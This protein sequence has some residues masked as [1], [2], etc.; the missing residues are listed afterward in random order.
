MKIFKIA[1][2]IIAYHGTT[3]ENIENI[4]KYGFNQDKIGD[5]YQTD[6]GMGFYFSSSIDVAKSFAKDVGG[7][8]IGVFKLNLNNPATNNDILNKDI[9]DS[10]DDDM[11]FT[12]VKDVLME[13]GFDGIAFTHENNTIEYV[14]YDSNKIIPVKIIKF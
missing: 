4:F 8:A 3:I 14:V 5:N 12:D 9:Q 6:W 2:E 13:Q 7:T 1:S 11:G 10:I